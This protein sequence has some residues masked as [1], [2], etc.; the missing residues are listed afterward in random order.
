[1]FAE[2]TTERMVQRLA[3]CNA[4]C[5]IIDFALVRWLKAD[6]DDDKENHNNDNFWPLSQRGRPRNCPPQFA[7]YA[8]DR[9]WGLRGRF[10]LLLAW[11]C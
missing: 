1:M 7:R 2:R 6:H 8:S 3:K 5:I 10:R 11:N 4:G 9:I